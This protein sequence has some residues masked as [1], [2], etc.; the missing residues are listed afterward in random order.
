M[1][2]EPFWL[3]KSTEVI[4]DTLPMLMLLCIPPLDFRPRLVF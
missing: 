3:H 2:C 1:L 4:I